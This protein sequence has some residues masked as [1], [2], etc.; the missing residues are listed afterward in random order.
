MLGFV[1]GTASL[2]KKRG[3]RSAQACGSAV[4]RLRLQ[5]GEPQPVLAKGR[6]PSVTAFAAAV[7]LAAATHSA[8][9]EPVQALT[10]QDVRQLSYEQVKGTGLANRCPEVVSSKGKISLDK[11]KKYKVV[12]LCLEPK[13]FLVEEEVGRRRGESKR[14]FVDTKLMTRA[15]YTLANIE[16][17][18]V[19]ENGTWKFI[20]KDGMD[21]AATTVQIPGGER[22]PFLFSIKKLVASLNNADDG[23][24]TSTELGGEFKV[25]SYRTGMFL[26]PKG[27]G[28]ANGYDMAVAL[29]AL[30]ADGAV[31]Q[32]V[33]RKENDKVFQETSGRIE[34]AVN[35]V[36]P[37]SNEPYRGKRVEALN[38]DE[39]FKSAL[40]R[41]VTQS[42]VHA[43]IVCSHVQC[44]LH[45]FRFERLDRLQGTR[46]LKVNTRYRDS[47]RTN[48]F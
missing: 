19:N 45:F 28:M 18:L 20:E 32:E 21:Y 39:E 3:G 43:R 15:T 26:D 9:L 8:V 25:P 47:F 7:L 35:K 46:T 22:V 36:D 30:E 12:D 10:A 33:L 13:Q 11:T 2:T 5:A 42:I 38:Q 44:W 23:I 27:R 48:K 14:E 6:L 4:T 40:A 41:Y 34:L 31:G 16:G 29:P 37:T 17:E 1:S 24:S